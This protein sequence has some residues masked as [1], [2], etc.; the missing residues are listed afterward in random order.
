MAVSTE[1]YLKFLESKTV[2]QVTWHHLATAPDPCPQHH[3]KHFVQFY[4]IFQ[5]RLMGLG[6]DEV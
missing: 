5:F 4:C 2:E 6:V 3:L 1:H